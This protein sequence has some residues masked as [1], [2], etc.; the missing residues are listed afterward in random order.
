MDYFAWSG[1]KL[2]L[3]FPVYNPNSSSVTITDFTVYGF[4]VK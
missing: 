2:M 3:N 4:L 1:G